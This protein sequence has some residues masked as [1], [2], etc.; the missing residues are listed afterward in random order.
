MIVNANSI[1]QHAKQVKN[2]TMK[3]FNVNIII[4]A[5]KIIGGI[6]AHVFVRMISIQKVLQILH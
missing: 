2:G 3:H 1:V 6:L 5:K 4:Y